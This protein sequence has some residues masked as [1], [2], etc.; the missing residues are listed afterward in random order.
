MVSLLRRVVF[1]AILLLGADDS[2]EG[3]RKRRLVVLYKIAVKTFPVKLGRSTREDEPSPSS[4]AVLP[5]YRTSWKAPEN[6]AIVV[7]PSTRNYGLLGRCAI[8]FSRF[9]V[10]FFPDF[11]ET[12]VR[13]SCSPPPLSEPLRGWHLR[14]YVETRGKRR[15]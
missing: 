3:R 14:R 15:R 5:N 2:E 10:I 12:H 4:F 11:V 7:N 13:D 1:Y 9:I 8:S 6:P